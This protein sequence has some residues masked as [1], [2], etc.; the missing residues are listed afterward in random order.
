MTLRLWM[1]WGCRMLDGANDDKKHDSVNDLGNK[2]KLLNLG[3]I[4]TDEEDDGVRPKS[5]P[6]GFGK[7]RSVSTPEPV[8]SARSSWHKLP[9]TPRGHK[10]LSSTRLESPK[11]H[12]SPRLEKKKKHNKNKLPTQFEFNNDFDS[13]IEDDNYANAIEYAVSLKR[14]TS[15]L[16]QDL[17]RHDFFTPKY[18]GTRISIDS[19]NNDLSAKIKADILD[20]EHELMQNKFN[21]YMQVLRT[22]LDINDFNDAHAVF[23]ALSS[24]QVSRLCKVDYSLSLRGE[25]QLNSTRSG[26]LEYPP[27]ALNRFL[28]ALY[29]FTISNGQYARM[30]KEYTRPGVIPWMIPIY[31][32]VNRIDQMGDKSHQERQVKRRAKQQLFDEVKKFKRPLAEIFDVDDEEI[33]VMVSSDE[34]F[35]AD[36]DNKSEAY[37]DSSEQDDTA[38]DIVLNEQQEMLWMSKLKKDSGPKLDNSRD[39]KHK[40]HKKSHHSTKTSRKKL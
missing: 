36:E 18:K 9:F 14:Q 35:E 13:L 33:P 3:D 22:L 34:S 7:N 24:A 4:S 29:L 15:E 23:C 19:A 17:T 25:V 20:A 21:F 30:I 10:K 8:K 37:H 6:R 5:L 16:F 27:S 2:L 40:G 31:M 26:F 1:T 38:S 28:D 39:V 12:S 11:K 32:K